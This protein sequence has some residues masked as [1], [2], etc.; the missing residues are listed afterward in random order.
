MSGPDGAWYGVGFNAETM[1]D[2]PYAII[3][4]GKGAITERK[5]GEHAPGSILASSVTEV[6]STVVGGIRTTVMTRPV[7][8]ATKDHYGFPTTPGDVNLITAVGNTPELA[9]HKSRTGGTLT[10]LPT[11][12]SACVCAPVVQ[13]YM[14]YMNQSTTH[15][16]NYDCLDEP[17]SDMLRHGDG[18]GRNL[19][20]SACAMNSYHG[21]LKCC[22]HTFFL[23]D[24]DQDPLIRNETDTY[25]LKWRYYF[26]EYTP[27]TAGSPAS[28]RHLHHWVFLIDANVNDYEEDSAD[29]GEASIGRISAHLTGK[30]IGLEDTPASWRTITPL[31]MTP[32]CHAPSCIREEFWN[33][34]TGE[35]IC[36]VTARYGEGRY[37]GLNEVFNEADYVAIPPCIFGDQ[38][39]L[40]TPFILGAN[41]NITAHK[42]F[43]NTYRHLG[44]MAQWTG[45]MVYDTDPY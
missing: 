28:H 18:T 41:T 1:A 22:Q 31:V 24:Q 35:I 2:A 32:H 42:Y 19:S 14:S 7:G 12:A 13:E 43:N 44:Q 5:L 34:D 26:Q 9:Y 20:N 3:V 15:W 33:A 4:D 10:L 45:L 30:D 37:G 29:Y 8:P 38:P 23:T 25:F 11:T 39:G 21:G 16:S 40:Q 27:A 17:R 6:S 36:N